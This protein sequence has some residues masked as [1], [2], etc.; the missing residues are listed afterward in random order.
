MKKKSVTGKRGGKRGAKDL[1]PRRTQ[2]L[3][4]GQ[5]ASSIQKKASDTS[6]AVI[7]KIG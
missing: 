4:G 2:D 3:K 1:T 7:G 5:L 6:A